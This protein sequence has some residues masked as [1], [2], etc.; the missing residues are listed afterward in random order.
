MSPASAAI[1]G[2]GGPTLTAPERALFARHPPLGFILFARNLVHPEQVRGLCQALRDCVGRAD[3]P[4]LIDQEG[5]RVARLRPPHWRLPPPAAVFGALATRD[6]DAALAAT[7]LNARLIADELAELGIDVD[8]APVLDVP[9]PGAHDII[10]DRAFA[11]DPLL[12]AELGQAMAEGLMAGGVLP[13][14]KHIPG[15]G[16][17]RADSHA[18][19]PAVEADLAALDARDFVPFRAL[20]WLPV[21]MTAHVRYPAID[22]L[23]PATCSRRVVAEI[24]R[25]RMGFDGLLV[26]DDVC[27]GAL[28]GPLPERAA[29]ALAAGC[30]VV[31]HCSG[32]SEEMAA[33]LPTLPGLD[34]AAARRLAAARA[35]VMARRDGG[36]DRLAACQELDALLGQPQAA[37]S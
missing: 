2:C 32:D 3:A 10:G 23:V 11:L 4:I 36:L 17:A 19:L 18:E 12:V 15:H 31:L 22:P 33:L 24:I 14:M 13:V 20:S 21:A 26:S 5:G 8:C 30:D 6:R 34:A 28:S 1:V 29:A 16:R 35:L 9:V 27:M 37:L 7:R 25:D